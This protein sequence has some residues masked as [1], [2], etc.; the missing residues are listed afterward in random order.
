MFPFSFTHLFIT[1]GFMASWLTL[2][3]ITIIIYFDVLIV[4][5]L[6]NGSTRMCP[7]C[8]RSPRCVMSS[9]F[10]PFLTFWYNQMFSAHL[11]LSLPQPWN[12]SFLQGAL[13]A[14]HGKW[15]P[16]T[17]SWVLGLLIA[18][19]VSLL[20]VPLSRRICIQISISLYLL[21]TTRL[22]WYHQFQSIT[23]F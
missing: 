11:L 12:Q 2:K 15:Y 7:L 10:K 23:T 1:D 16:G 6:I 13:L 9:S 8:V 18:S 3:S 21:K 20:V 22:Y 4:L 19:H 5:D 17:M 14:F